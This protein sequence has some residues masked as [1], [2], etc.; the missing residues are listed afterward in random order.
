MDM[1]ELRPRQSLSYRRAGFLALPLILVLAGSVTTT[2][3][4]NF[5]VDTFN[6]DIAKW[7]G[8]AT[9]LAFDPTQDNTGNG[10]GSCRVTADFGASQSMMF[11]GTY[12]PGG[13]WE[14]NMVL[15]LSNYKSL[16]F[17]VKWDTNS[18]MSLAEFNHPPSGG[19]TPISIESLKP[20][21]SGFS[22]A[23]GSFTIPDAATNRPRRTV[24]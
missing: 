7:W 21:W 4:T 13:V 15:Y 2:R 19:F 16:D 20:G 14:S 9:T 12:G 1:N 23:F 10:S 5:V 11:V 17:D 18:S 22:D 8:P 24:I 3:A 6:H